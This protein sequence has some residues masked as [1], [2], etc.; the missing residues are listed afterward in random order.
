MSSSNDIAEYIIDAYTYYGIDFHSTGDEA[1][2]LN[3]PP[4]FRDV[5]ELCAALNEE[6][7]CIV[8]LE[9]D[10]TNLR[11]KV[12][13]THISSMPEAK[14]TPKTQ[15]ATHSY[16]ILSG[17]QTILMICIIILALK[18]ASDEHVYIRKTISKLLM[19]IAEAV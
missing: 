11:A 6:F 2:I 1:I 3:L 19:N 14:V 5:T 8:D 4:F 7:G 15:V 13:T 9:Y 17:I 12:W 10:N 16:S 18:F